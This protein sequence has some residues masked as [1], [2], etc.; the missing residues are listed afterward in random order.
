MQYPVYQN[1]YCTLYYLYN[2]QSTTIS[3]LYVLL[4]LFKAWEAYYVMLNVG[5]DGYSLTRI[6][7]SSKIQNT[8]KE[9]FT[10]NSDIHYANICE[11]RWVYDGYRVNTVVIS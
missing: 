1:R 11:L 8:H 7:V 2:I 3:K 6:G 5:Q 9:N 10:Q 4:I